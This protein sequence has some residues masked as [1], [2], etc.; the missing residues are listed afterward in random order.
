MSNKNNV[1]W[2][3]FYFL[4]FLISLNFVGNLF[5]LPLEIEKNSAC[6]V[7][8]LGLPVI[9]L[10]LHSFLTLSPIRAIFF[11][12]LASCTGWIMEIWGLHTG[13]FFGGHY[14]YT[15]NQLMLLNIPLS[16]I[17]YWAVFIYTG[18]CVV[19]SFIYWLHKQKPSRDRKNLWLLPIAVLLDGWVVVAIDLF[20]DPLQVQSGGWRWLEG[21]PYFGVPIGN[22]IGWFIVIIIVTGIFRTFEYLFPIK[23]TKYDKTVYI[24]PVTGY[25]ALAISFALKA[26]QH[27]MQDLAVIGSALMLPIVIFNVILFIKWKKK[28]TDRFSSK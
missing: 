8:F 26:I 23:E 16:V 5:G 4:L 13:T 21:G 11:I 12:T 19:N 17:L 10:I 2:I 28:T 14:V 6:K 27:Q 24:I 25:G 9:L 15:S 22:F 18:Y 3:V 7:L 1:M 20:M